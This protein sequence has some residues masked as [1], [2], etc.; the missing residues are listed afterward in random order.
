MKEYQKEYYILNKEAI[1]E[2]TSEYYKNN[3]E[4]FT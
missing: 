3:T 4:I 2:K 1:I